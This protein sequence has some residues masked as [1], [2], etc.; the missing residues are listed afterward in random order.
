VCGTG[1]GGSGSLW[2][3]RHIGEQCCAELLPSH[4]DLPDQP[5]G[6]LFRG[7]RACSV[8]SGKEV[9]TDMIARRSGAIVNISS[10]AAI[11]PGRGPYED[12]TVRGGVMYGAT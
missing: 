3:D 1:R 9:L 4:R 6:A 5:L 11:G 7:Q 10:G 2:A 12:R 8:H